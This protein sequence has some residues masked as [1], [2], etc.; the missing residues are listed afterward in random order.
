M[1]KR[2]LAAA[3]GVSAVLAGLQASFFA[4]SAT[5]DFTNPAVQLWV[6]VLGEAVSCAAAF[7]GFGIGARFLHFAWTG[8]RELK[9]V[10]LR[11]ALISVGLFFPGFIF[12][13]PLTFFLV[14]RT[15]Q[16]GD[17]ALQISLGIGLIAVIVGATW[18][19]K[20]RNQR[21]PA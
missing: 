6:S 7:V 10:W 11:S 4:V 14:G 17:T 15:W 1:V 18:F 12:S 20:R 13:L 5:D 2:I 16:N 21:I 19:L 9:S 8:R 3:M